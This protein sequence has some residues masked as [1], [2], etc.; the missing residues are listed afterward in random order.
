[1][2]SSADYRVILTDYIL[3]KVYNKGTKVLPRLLSTEG[4]YNGYLHRTDAGSN[5]QKLTLLTMACL[6]NRP[7]IVQ[8]LLDHF[9]LDLEVLNDVYLGGKNDAP[10]IFYDV[11][12]LWVAAAKENFELVQLL[13]ERGARVNHTT[14]RRIELVDM[15]SSH[16]SLLEQI[17]AKELLG[18]FF[19]RETDDE[20]D[21]GQS[22]IYLHQAL[23]LRSLHQLPKVLASP[24][25]EICDH[26]Q[27]CQTL[28][29]LEQVYKNADDIHIEALLVA[30][31]LLGCVHAK[32]LYSLR[33][34]GASLLDN[35]E[36]DRG[37][38]VWIYTTSLTSRDIHCR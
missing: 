5:E 34:W 4:N 21:P 8:I 28:E 3:L 31:R 32:Y 37:L 13:V 35:K 23:E 38:A 6:E 27:E 2:E 10:S 36:Y 24:T 22:F 33:L 11:T 29:Q 15:I 20:S 19:A 9:E 18:N 1:M 17:E 7:D 30:E 14:K 25:L 12:A 26:R 16:C